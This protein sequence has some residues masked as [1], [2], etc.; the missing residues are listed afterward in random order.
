MEQLKYKYNHH[1]DKLTNYIKYLYA[2]FVNINK[3]DYNEDEQ[4]WIKNQS[5]YVSTNWTKDMHIDWS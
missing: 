4:Q 3:K 1:E 5:G 2:K